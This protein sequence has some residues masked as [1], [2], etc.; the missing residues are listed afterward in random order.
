ME[1]P[2]TH[3]PTCTPIFLTHTHSFPQIPHPHP[4]PM[5]LLCLHMHMA[6]AC[7]CS[8][9]SGGWGGMPLSEDCPLH[10]S[11]GTKVPCV[12]VGSPTPQP[13]P[14][15]WSPCSPGVGTGAEGRSEAARAS[16]LALRCQGCGGGSVTIAQFLGVRAPPQPGSWCHRAFAP[17]PLWVG[18]WSHRM[19]SG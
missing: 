10:G 18:L 8:Q 2:A 4:T 1:T 11:A 6:L 19:S 5:L 16:V 9:L 12:P 14:L 17:L 15:L 3:Q 13:F 7:S